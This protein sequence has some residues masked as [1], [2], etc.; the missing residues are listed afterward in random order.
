MK[1]AFQILKLILIFALPILLQAF[2]SYKN[3]QRRVTSVQ[4]ERLGNSPI[5]ITDATIKQLLLDDI[6]LKPFVNS[7][8]INKLEERLD[9]NAM[10][11]QADVFVTLNGVL[12]A[13]IQQ[14]QPIARLFNE[15]SFSYL[16][17]KGEKMPL[18]EVYSAR[19]PLVLGKVDAKNQ[20]DLYELLQ[21]IRSDK[22]L[23]QNITEISVKN[24]F[25]RLRMRIPTFEVVLGDISNLSLKFNHLKAFY[26]KANKDN[27]LNRYK[28]VNLQYSNQVVCS[29]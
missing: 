23:E 5:F 24:N 22:F 26:K 12:K 20:S 7:L 9:N 8:K 17:N 4:I 3:K 19:V 28:Q 29:K 11:E 16:D 1:K 15:N 27:F 13:R 2:A 10:I 14:R 6:S 21:F 18:S 25:F